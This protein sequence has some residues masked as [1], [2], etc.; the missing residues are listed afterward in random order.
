M[1]ERTGVIVPPG[2]PQLI[3]AMAEGHQEAPPVH[4][5]AVTRFGNS[6]ALS[7]TPWL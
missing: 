5:S 3:W 4:F 7:P 2:A 6:P 1:R